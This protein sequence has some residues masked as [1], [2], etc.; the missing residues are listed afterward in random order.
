M[1]QLLG[2]LNVSSLQ[3]PHNINFREKKLKTSKKDKKTEGGAGDDGSGFKGRVARFRY[4]EDISG[5]SG[6]RCSFHSKALSRATTICSPDCAGDSAPKLV[7]PSGVYLRALPTLDAG[8]RTRGDEAPPHDNRW[9]NRIIFPIPQHQLPQGISLFQQ[10]GERK[11]WSIELCQS[12]VKE[13]AVRFLGSSIIFI[14]FIPYL[15]I[16]NV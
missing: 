5:Y 1:K 14:T 8:D 6:V 2:K 13:R 4:F 16:K 12:C 10:A 15:N 11:H 9:P 3:L 7:S